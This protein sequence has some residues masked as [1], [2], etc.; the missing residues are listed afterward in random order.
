VPR[1]RNGRD[2]DRDEDGCRCGRHAR[3]ASSF[4][5]RHRFTTRCQRDRKRQR[6]HREQ[7]R[8]AGVEVD[9]GVGGER[10]HRDAGDDHVWVTAAAQTLEDAP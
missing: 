9:Q 1:R 7:R 10:E 6:Q 5:R 4:F 3:H 8:V 2:R